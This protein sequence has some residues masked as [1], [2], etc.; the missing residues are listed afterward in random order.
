MMAF[1]LTE[2]D[3]LN[4]FPCTPNVPSEFSDRLFEDGIGGDEERANDEGGRQRWA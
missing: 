3:Q 2:R 1:R 4:D